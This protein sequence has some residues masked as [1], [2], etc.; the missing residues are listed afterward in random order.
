MAFMDDLRTK[1]TNIAD[2]IRLKVGAYE[3]VMMPDGS[4]VEEKK[5]FTLDNMVTAINS[6]ENSSSTSEI[7]NGYT[8]K[9]YKANNDLIEVHSALAGYS[10]DAPINYNPVKWLDESNNTVVTFPF[11]SSEA[12]EVYEFK[13]FNG[14]TYT[15]RL[16][17]FFGVTNYKYVVVLCKVDW[18]YVFFTDFI[19]EGDG[20]NYISGGRTRSIYVSTGG[21]DTKDMDYIMDYIL[22]QED[23]VTSSH[24]AIYPFSTEYK[25]GFT[26]GDPSLIWPIDGEVYSLNV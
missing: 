23:N 20:Y 16:C 5:V 26:N 3:Q 24:G 6:I 7:E 22:S 25:V 1:L 2:A 18:I 4:V 13:G 11:T 10:I 21:L 14:T 17:E 19:D 15:D 8:A 12:G 9:F